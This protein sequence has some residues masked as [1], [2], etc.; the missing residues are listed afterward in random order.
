MGAQI[1]L[2][3]PG[4]SPREYERSRQCGQRLKQKFYQLNWMFPARIDELHVL[5]DGFTHC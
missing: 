1:I 3:V 4:K 2:R 5:A